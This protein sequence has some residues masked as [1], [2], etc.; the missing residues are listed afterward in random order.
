[1][2]AEELEKKVINYIK[3]R[4]EFLTPETRPL[5]LK[6]AVFAS[7]SADI[8]DAF[9]RVKALSEISGEKYFLKAAKVCERTSNILKGARGEK[10]GAVDQSLLKEDLEKE[11][12]KAYSAN[13]NRIKDL[14]DKEDYKEATKAYADVFFEILHKFFDNVLVNAE[15]MALR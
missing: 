9:A 2:N 4:L 5:E 13:E 3:E 11:V 8:V 15:D 12:W 6:Q 10:I 7:G 14:I 1:M